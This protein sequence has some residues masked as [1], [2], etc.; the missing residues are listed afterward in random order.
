MRPL[1]S[2]CGVQRDGGTARIRDLLRKLFYPRAYP[3]IPFLFFSRHQVGRHVGKGDSN[4]L[5]QFRLAFFL[6]ASP[7]PKISKHIRDILVC[8][9]PRK[10]GTSG[11]SVLRIV[12]FSSVGRRKTTGRGLSKD[13]EEL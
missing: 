12:T 2:C 10:T 8:P 6:I 7:L 1:G 5:V 13:N 4:P 11:S 9:H 3:L